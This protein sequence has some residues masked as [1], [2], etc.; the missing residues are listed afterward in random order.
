MSLQA[1]S[2]RAQ[3]RPAKVVTSF[4]L[5]VALRDRLDKEAI[6]LGRTRNSLAE[7]ALAKFLDQKLD[8]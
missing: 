2:E 6:S 5:P 4:N 3:Y 1:V 7:E 8:T